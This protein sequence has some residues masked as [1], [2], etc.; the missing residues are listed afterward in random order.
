MAIAFCTVSTVVKGQMVLTM[1]KALDIATEN[2]PTLKRSFM[3]LERSQQNL[4]AQRAALKSKFSLNLNPVS[5]SKNRKF[6]DRISQW[7]TN[8]SFSSQGTFQIDQ[9][10]L[11]TDGVLSLINTFGWQSNNSNTNGGSTTNRAFSNDLYLKLTQPIFTYNKTKMELKELEYDTENMLISYALQRLSTERSITNQFY[12]VYSAQNSLEISKEELKNAEQNYEIIKN[13]VEADLSAKDELFQAE[14]NLSTA[15]ST[16]EDRIV[17]LENA[18]DQLKQTLGMSLDEEIT[19]TAEVKAEPVKIDLEKAIEH[20]LNSRLELR[21]REITT[22]QLDFQM[23]RTKASNE[24]KGDISLSVGIMGDNQHFE[25]IYETPTSN[26]RVAVSFNVPIFDWGEKKA[27]IKAQ[28]TAMRI[29]ELEADEEKK[30][31][32]M[33]IRQTYRNLENQLRQ[34]DL[35]EQS[36]K[37]AEQTYDLNLE[38]YRN[39]DLTGMEMSQFQTQLSNKRMSYIQ[40]LINYKIELLNMKILSLYNF[41]T[42]QPIV[43]LADL[44]DL[45]KKKKKK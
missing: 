45:T 23:I 26:P 24:F 42:D 30:E 5:Y 11:W 25:K 44:Q 29:N 40:T 13:K 39:G 33:N 6:E 1:E 2:S 36:V 38:R 18:K 28:E 19:T 21:Q 34:I 31:I 22:K 10:I 32:E 37:N 3:N 4:I 7:Y 16:V 8:E 12:A 35:A 9:P 14:L 17:S 43:P 41:E 20:A 27:R 15:Q